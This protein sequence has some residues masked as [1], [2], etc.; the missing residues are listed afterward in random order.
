MMTSLWVVPYKEGRR[1]LVWARKGK[2]IGH[3][4]IYIKILRK[5][6]LP[7]HKK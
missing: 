6:T 1:G 2:K 5:R 7:K 4:R 3:E